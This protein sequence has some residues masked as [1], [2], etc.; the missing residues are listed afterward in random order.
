MN[1]FLT[2]NLALMLDAIGQAYSTRPSDIMGF[3]HAGRAMMF[4]IKVR[5]MAQM[6]LEI[7]QKKSKT[8]SGEFKAKKRDWPEWA[9]EVKVGQ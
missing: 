2:P 4:D 7:L 3:I 5:A 6:E 9:K 1:H 8:V